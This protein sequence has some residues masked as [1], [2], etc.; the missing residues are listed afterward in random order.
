MAAT[1]ASLY[2]LGGALMLDHGLFSN[3][4][5]IDVGLRCSYQHLQSFTGTADS[6]WARPRRE[7]LTS[8]CAAAPPRGT[9]PC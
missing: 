5:D 1:S 9:G 2:G 6:I 7:N 8:T 3:P 4:R